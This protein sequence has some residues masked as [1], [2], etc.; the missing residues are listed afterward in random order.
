M[1]HS[2]TYDN[3]ATSLVEFQHDSTGLWLGCVRAE[4]DQMFSAVASA[5]L[6]YEINDNN[7]DVVLV[8]HW[9]LVIGCHPLN[10]FRSIEALALCRLWPALICWKQRPGSYSV[11]CTTVA[12]CGW[13]HCIN[14]MQ[15]LLATGRKSSK[16]ANVRICYMRSM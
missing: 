11:R 14:K 15:R 8:A 5:Q 1:H 9:P 3:A 10:P 12:V 2:C 7:L 6:S 4:C 13:P 16:Q